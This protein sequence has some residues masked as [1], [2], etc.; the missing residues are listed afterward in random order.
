MLGFLN[1]KERAMKKQA[2]RAAEEEI[3]RIDAPSRIRTAA[4]RCFV[5]GVLAILGGLFANANT[6]KFGG[7]AYT[8]I[9]KQTAEVSAAVVWLAAVVLFVG[10]ALLKALA[11]IL[12]EIRRTG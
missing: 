4:S 9:V 8:E 3:R 6:P 5:F 10:G 2:K 12:D 7:D 1:R 11:D